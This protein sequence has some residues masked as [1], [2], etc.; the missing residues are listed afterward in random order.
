M[1]RR[2]TIVIGGS[3]GAIEVLLTIV[4]ALPADLPAAVFVVVHVSPGA[5]SRLPEI[6]TRAGRLPA[7]HAEHGQAIEPGRIYVAPPDRHLLVR[8]GYLE[9]NRGPRENHTRPAIDPLFRSAARAFGTRAIGVILSGALYDGSTGLLA[10]KTRGGIAIVQDPREAIT[11][12]MPQSALRLVD[13]DYV[14]PAL[15]IAPH[16]VGL[17]HG[18]L[19]EEGGS[20]VDETERI[21]QT[22]EHDFVEQAANQ[23]GGDTALYTCPDCGGVLWQAEEGGGFHCHVGHAYAAESLLVHKSEELESALWACV[24]L[25][26]ERATLTRQSATRTLEGGNRELAARFEEQALLAERQGQAIRELL[27][28]TPSPADQTDVIFAAI[29]I[30]SPGAP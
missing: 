5:Y 22:I 25:L 14:L 8:H 9:L 27:E 10:I 7:T 13:V 17:V 15:A 11:P 4:G 30:S 20:D 19:A 21:T 1:P 29:G 12:S 24:R 16:L 23:R 2:D 18:A 26:R 6:L 28:A 3:A